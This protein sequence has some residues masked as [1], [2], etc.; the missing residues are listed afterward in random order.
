MKTRISTNS[1]KFMK[2]RHDSSRLLFSTISQRIDFFALHISG[3]KKPPKTGTTQAGSCFLTFFRHDSSRLLFFDDFSHFSTRWKNLGGRY[4]IIPTR[5]VQCTCRRL[6]SAQSMV[7]RTRLSN[8][9]RSPPRRALQ[10]RR[11]QS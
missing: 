1:Y 9:Q 11:A 4:S 3:T 8:P 10:W 2:I 7:P 6:Q 5:P